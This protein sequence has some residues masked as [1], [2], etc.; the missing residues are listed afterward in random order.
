MITYN[1]K[2]GIITRG[3]TTAILKTCFKLERMSKQTHAP[4]IDRNFIHGVKFSIPIAVL[5]HTYL[6]LEMPALSF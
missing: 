2:Q 1:L 4:A 6:F 3:K 5:K